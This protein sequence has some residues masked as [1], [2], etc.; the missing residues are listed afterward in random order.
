MNTDLRRCLLAPLCLALAACSASPVRT[1][2]V[3]EAPLRALL[4]YSASSPRPSAET[5]RERPATGDPYLLMQ[6]AIQLANARPPELQRA[7][8]LLEGVLKSSHPYAADLAPLARLLHEQYGERLRLEQQWRD[9]Q[10]RGDQLQEKIDALTA[11]ERSL[12]ARPAPKNP[13]GGTP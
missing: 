6:Q 11:I 1:T 8:L 7:S 9:A 13:T 12:P 2:P 4:A 5:L 3:E 10:R